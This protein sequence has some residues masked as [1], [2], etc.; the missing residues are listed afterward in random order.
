MPLKRLEDKVKV[1]KNKEKPKEMEVSQPKVPRVGMATKP[2]PELN[3][4]IWSE[5]NPHQNNF[6]VESRLVF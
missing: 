2:G 5:F 4:K 6:Y 1:M 3:P